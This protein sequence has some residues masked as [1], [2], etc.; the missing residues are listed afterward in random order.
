LRKT[1]SE[2]F[3]GLDSKKMSGSLRDI[4]KDGSKMLS[5]SRRAA[6]ERCGSDRDLTSLKVRKAKDSFE[7]SDWL[8]SCYVD[9]FDKEVRDKEPKTRRTRTIVVD[10]QP[11]STNKDDSESNPDPGKSIP[12]RES[13][14]SSKDVSSTTTRAA[15]PS[16]HRTAS[17]P[18]VYKSKQD[19]PAVSKNSNFVWNA[20]KTASTSD[21]SSTS[22]KERTPVA[23]SCSNMD[24]NESKDRRARFGL[25][26]AFQSFRQLPTGATISKSNSKTNLKAVLRGAMQVVEKGHSG[27]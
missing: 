26:R 7:S 17:M 4:K 3:T 1:K 27:R 10:D 15:R 14:S 21:T 25:T 11:D 9:T 6:P 12:N 23:R 19:A 22:S 20:D 8:T 13:L 18:S 2:R 5:S 24:G 16:L